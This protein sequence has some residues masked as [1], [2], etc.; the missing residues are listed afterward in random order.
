[1]IYEEIFGI[2][3]N[4]NINSKRKGDR[5]EYIAAKLWTEWSGI[6]WHRVPRSGGLRWKSTQGTI[7]DLI[8]EKDIGIAVET[9]HLKRIS[10]PKKL[11]SN[12]MIYNIWNKSLLEAKDKV[13]IL[14]LRSNGMS[15]NT[16][17][18][19]V[20]MKYKDVIEATPVSY[21]DNIIIYNSKDIFKLPF[22][23]VLECL[24]LH[25]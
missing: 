15:K 5:N 4:S 3:S 19:V 9:K 17:W 24:L 1:M 23:D 13:T 12:S 25:K 6:E 11:R 2:Q 21:G 8:P 20:D 18:F 22:N 16:Y 7:L 14:F 10:V